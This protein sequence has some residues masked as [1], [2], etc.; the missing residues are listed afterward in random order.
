MGTIGPLWYGSYFYSCSWL[1]F[2]QI[3]LTAYSIYE[4]HDP[5]A[6]LMD[7][8]VRMSARRNLAGARAFGGQSVASPVSPP[9]AGGYGNLS[10]EQ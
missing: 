10:A 8:S 2:I 9:E 7:S 3:L 4:P 6:R 5:L 1:V